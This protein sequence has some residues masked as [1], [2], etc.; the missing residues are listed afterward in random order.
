M[1]RKSSSGWLKHFDFIILDLLCLQVAFALAYI[2]R[3]GFSNPYETEIYRNMAVFLMFADVVLIFFGETFS[4]VLRRGYYKEFAK[5]IK[6]SALVDG[7]AMVYL[8]SAKEGEQWA[9]SQGVL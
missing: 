5:T 4:G 3:Q 1:Y 7:L 6:H 2:L 9:H 8:F